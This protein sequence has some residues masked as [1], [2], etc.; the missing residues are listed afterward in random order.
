VPKHHTQALLLS[1]QQRRQGPA[2]GM[3][4]NGCTSA[5]RAAHGQA[6]CSARAQ[7]TLAPGEQCA[8]ADADTAH[9]TTQTMCPMPQSMACTGEVAV[10]LAQVQTQCT[11]L[12]LSQACC[13]SALCPFG[14]AAAMAALTC[15]LLGRT[16]RSCHSRLC[17]RSCICC[18]VD[19]SVWTAKRIWRICQPPCSV[20]MNMTVSPSC[21]GASKVPL[22]RRGSKQDKCHE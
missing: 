3:R 9:M 21:K 22:H 8:C 5:Q 20:L 4:L 18:T 2:T 1:Q 13:Q 6:R 14:G 15:K 16:G 10:A 12:L 17:V 7:N 11:S 19:W